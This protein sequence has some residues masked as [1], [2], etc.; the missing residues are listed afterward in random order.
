MTQ[1][2]A[3][4]ARLLGP[5]GAPLA[6]VALVVEAYDVGGAAWVAQGRA[7]SADDGTAKGRITLAEAALAPA[8]RLLAGDAVV[9]SAPD[10]AR[11]PRGRALQADF[12]DVV[13]G[14]AS[15]GTREDPTVLVGLPR[16]LGRVPGG[17]VVGAGTG[18]VGTGTVGTGTVLNPDIIRAQVTDEVSKRFTVQLA[19]RDRLLKDRDT[20]LADR[21]RVIG[22]KDREIERLA[23]VVTARD[24]AL[25]DALAAAQAQNKTPQ[26]V[27]VTDFTTSLG[28]QLHDAQTALKT[29]SFSIAAVSINARGVLSDGG[30]KITL[31]DKADDRAV[32]DI[33][34]NFVPDAVAGGDDVLK[35]PDV[36][37]L[38]EGAARRVLASVGLVLEAIIGPRSLNSAVAPGQAMLQSPVPGTPV[39]RGARILVTFAAET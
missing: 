8:L 35:V 37:Q 4:T 22:D 39:Q 21:I 30:R 9:A 38:T 36:G 10:L 29:R 26:P 25:A 11:P 13:L 34:V 24:K 23:G 14:G 12:G 31:P 27:P 18:T 28:E 3:W 19:D 20:Q 1:A 2:L 15:G 5:D 17:V 7:G 16:G 33:R 6:G 32:S